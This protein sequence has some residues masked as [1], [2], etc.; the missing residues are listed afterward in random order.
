MKKKIIKIAVGWESDRR[1]NRVVSITNA[2][3]YDPGQELPDTEVE[4][5][6]QTI[7]W[8]VIRIAIHKKE[9]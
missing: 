3:D 6:C 2:S 5:L 8:D 1:V 9:G 4:H 7:G